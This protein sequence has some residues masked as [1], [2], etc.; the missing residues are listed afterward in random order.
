MS[1]RKKNNKNQNRQYYKKRKTYQ[2]ETTQFCT[3][4]QNPD[5]TILS[6][7]GSIFK[8]LVVNTKAEGV[9]K[10]KNF[11]LNV[12]TSYKQNVTDE[13]IKEMMPIVFAL[14]YV[15]NEQ[16]PLNLTPNN[17][18]FQTLYGTNN[19]VILYGV[20]NSGKQITLRSKLAR[21]LNAGDS[22]VLK[23]FNPNENPLKDLSFYA[24][25]NYAIA[26]N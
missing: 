24:S 25:L 7:N 16:Q 3:T 26:Y 19:Y 10:V 6:A 8:T 11:T 12:T 14:I 1:S 13:N 20:C 22:I 15:P 21:N 17:A 2:N 18:D 4:G 23:L 9:R 5:Q